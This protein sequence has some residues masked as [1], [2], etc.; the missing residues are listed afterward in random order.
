MT[1]NVESV[2]NGGDK[3]ERV[4]AKGQRR[5]A[6]SR[7]HRTGKSEADQDQAKGQQEIPQPAPLDDPQQI[8]LSVQEP[9]ETE[10]GAEPHQR[11]QVGDERLIRRPHPHYI[12]PLLVE[13][14]RD[15][16]RDRQDHGSQR[17]SHDPRH[18]PIE[19]CAHRA[20]RIKPDDCAAQQKR[21]CIKLQQRIGVE[22]KSTGAGGVDALVAIALDQPENADGG[23]EALFRMRPRPQDDVDQCLGIGT[24][25]GGFETMRS[26]SS[27]EAGMRARH[28]LGNCRRAMRQR[29]AQMRCHP[30]AAQENLDGLLDDPRLD[31]LMHEVV[32]DAVV[33]L[34]DLDVIIET[35]PA[36]SGRRGG[37][38]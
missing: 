18:Q 30:L 9:A 13:A 36:R 19:R 11:L 10:C 35:N 16:D 2:Q 21:G 5:R 27:R 8:E 32:G 4:G 29:A 33:M 23:A 7:Q 20:G 31:L 26:W 12:D 14:E 17:I 6:R 22:Q 28:M 25:L 38:G 37:L 15:A 1:V 3:P 34:G 24:D